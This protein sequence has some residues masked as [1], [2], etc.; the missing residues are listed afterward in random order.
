M[1]PNHDIRIQ[2]FNRPDHQKKNHR[3]WIASSDHISKSANAF[4]SKQRVLNIQTGAEYSS[5][6]SDF[7]PKISRDNKDRKICLK[8]Q[9][10][11][12]SNSQW[13]F[14][15]PNCIDLEHSKH[16]IKKTKCN[17]L[18]RKWIRQNKPP[19]RPHSDSG[20]ERIQNYGRTSENIFLTISRCSKIFLRF[21]AAGHATGWPAK[22]QVKPWS[23]M[24]RY[25]IDDIFPPY[26]I[27]VFEM[28]YLRYLW[29]ISY[30]DIVLIYR[31]QILKTYTIS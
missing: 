26:D 15:E 27:V 5:I 24:I 14:D 4:E 23:K 18:K 29:T 20:H 6:S 3:R 17:K 21:F 22:A 7:V 16:I 9:W 2:N 11:Q 19:L 1:P 12:R 25:R 8:I 30:C 31:I 28:V 13:K 10:N